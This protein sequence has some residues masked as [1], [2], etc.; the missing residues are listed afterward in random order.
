MYFEGVIQD[1][2]MFIAYLT[3]AGKKVL[4]VA[5]QHAGLKL[6]F[7]ALKVQLSGLKA[8]NEFPNICPL[9]AKRGIR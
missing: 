2:Y 5:V 7:W 6:R 3:F 4:I 9:D 8:D 1:F